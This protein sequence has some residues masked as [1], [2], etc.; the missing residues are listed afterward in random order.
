[1]CQERTA[2]QSEW[3]FRF[4]VFGWVGTW[5]PQ[6]C[7]WKTR[8]PEFSSCWRHFSNHF[9]PICIYISPFLVQFVGQI[10]SHCKVL[11]N[12]HLC[13]GS[14]LL[15]LISVVAAPRPSLNMAW[16][17]ALQHRG[18]GDVQRRQPCGLCSW[19][20]GSKIRS[21]QTLEMW[22]VSSGGTLAVLK[23]QNHK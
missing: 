15:M 17:E 2:I 12:D 23:C 3:P 11:R 14:W 1:M 8:M 16:H 9:K 4:A 22:K 20:W 5:I 21:L 7:P 6:G 18:R 10:S 19:T 13:S